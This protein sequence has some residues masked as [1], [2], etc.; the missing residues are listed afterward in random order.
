MQPL[1]GAVQMP[2][3]SLQQTWPS[4]QRV[5]PQRMRCGVGFGVGGEEEGDDEEERVDDGEDD[6]DWQ[7]SL[8]HPFPGGVQIPQEGL[9]HVWPEGQ[10]FGPHG[11]PVFESGSARFLGGW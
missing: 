10:V 9:Q 5:G 2:H 3:E 11:G 6:G 4:G 1:P 8:T 7:R